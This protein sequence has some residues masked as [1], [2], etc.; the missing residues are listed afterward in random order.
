MKIRF[1]LLLLVLGGVLQTAVCAQTSNER[2]LV[3]LDKVIS[4]KEKYR[5]EREAAIEQLKQRLHYASSN[6]EKW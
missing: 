1:Y 3:Q 2:I 5:S 6:E 4:Q